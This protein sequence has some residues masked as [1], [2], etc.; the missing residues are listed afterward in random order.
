MPA[1]SPTMTHGTITSWTKKPGDKCSAGDVLC[2][3]ETDKATVA[4]EVSSMNFCHVFF[5]GG[6]FLL[7]KCVISHQVQDDYVLAKIVEQAGARE[8]KVGELVALSVEDEAAYEVFIKLDKAGGIAA[9]AQ[10]APTP[11][12]PVPEPPKV[13]APIAHSTGPLSISPAARH[14]IQSKGISH[15]GIVGSGKAGMITKGDVLQALASGKVIAK[16]A[17]AAVRAPAP[18]PVAPPVS[19]ST[20]KVRRELYSALSR[21]LER[22]P[23]KKKE[24]IFLFRLSSSH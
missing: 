1:L 8:V 9:P 12:P 7:K 14:W 20:A 11:A 21:N 2:E 17:E 5:I 15:V 4:F 18:L 19:A 16:P 13:A 10:K 23:S 22:I 3:I 6:L 24:R